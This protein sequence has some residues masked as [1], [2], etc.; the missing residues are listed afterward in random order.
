MTRREIRREWVCKCVLTIVT[1]LLDPLGIRMLGSTP[2][3]R[4]GRTGKGAEGLARCWHRQQ[5]KEKGQAGGQPCLPHTWPWK[6]VSRERGSARWKS[7]WLQFAAPLQVSVFSS[8]LDEQLT[9]PLR[10]PWRCTMASDLQARQ[11]ATQFFEMILMHNESQC[12]QGPLVSECGNGGQSM[13]SVLWGRLRALCQEPEYTVG[14]QPG[15][16]KRQ[17]SDSYSATGSPGNKPTLFSNWPR[18]QACC[19]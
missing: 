19:L 2:K 13:G 8:R 1:C 17:D 6:Q 14:Q 7:C 18:K 15:H 4:S 11:S 12:V 16:I 10:W 5:G 3:R 9:E